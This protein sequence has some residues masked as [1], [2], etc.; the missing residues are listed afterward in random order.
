V[1]PVI[2]FLNLFIFSPIGDENCEHA[3]KLVYLILTKIQSLILRRFRSRSG[4]LVVA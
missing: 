2:F 4:L 1:H 3:D